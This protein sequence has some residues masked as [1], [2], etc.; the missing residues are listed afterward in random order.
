MALRLDDT[1]S[2]IE[3]RAGPAAEGMVFVP[4]GTFAMGSDKHYPEEAPVHRVTVDGFW[5]DETPVTNRAVP[6]VRRGDRLR[7]L[8]RDRARAPRTIPARCRTC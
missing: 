5:M 6:R 7:H 8:R 4:G 1:Q 3:A 2:G